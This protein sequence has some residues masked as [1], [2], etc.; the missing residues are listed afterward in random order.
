M[1]AANCCAC[2]SSSWMSSLERL[3][4][5]L[6]ADAVGVDRVRD[7]AHHRLDLH[8]VGLLEQVRRSARAWRSCRRRGCLGWR[9]GWSPWRSLVVRVGA[10]GAYPRGR[11][12]SRRTVK[13]ATMA[14]DLK[15]KKIAILV[16]NE[17]VEQVE[18]TEPRQAV[19]DAGAQTELVSVRGGRRRRP[20]TTS[21][22]PTAFQV[23]EGGVRRPRRRLR[24]AAA[25]RRRREPRPAAH[26]SRHGRVRP[27]VLRRR[28][29]GRR[30]LPRSVD[31]DR[32]R[33]RPRPHADLVAVAA[34]R[35]AQRGRRPGSTRRS[36]WTTGS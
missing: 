15:G 7:V 12:C 13:H 1:R 36:M 3:D 25:P 8:P 16:A 27:R 31:A 9:C 21:T 35:P 18:L 6:G 33:R 24:R 5:L 20:S 28:Q 17:G 34:D 11:R 26:R 2:P 30:H 14:N 32:G 19:E 10:P 23:D 22:R 4:D 29:A